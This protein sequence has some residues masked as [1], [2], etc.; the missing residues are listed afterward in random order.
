MKRKLILSGMILGATLLVACEN[1]EKQVQKVMENIK[2]A[3]YE[4]AYELYEEKIV[5][6]SEKVNDLEN[7]IKKYL[8]NSQQE[9]FEE[10]IDY[11]RLCDIIEEVKKYELEDLEELLTEVE[12]YGEKF[13]NSRTAYV[14]A[15]EYMADGDYENAMKYYG[16]V[17]ADDSYAEEAEKKKADVMETYKKEIL[18]KAEE[19][20]GEGNYD[21]ALETINSGLDI[22]SYDEDLFAKI[23]TYNAG[24]E[25]QKIGTVL[26]E[27]KSYYDNKDYKTAIQTLE[28]ANVLYHA[29]AIETTLSEYEAEYLKMVLTEAEQAFTTGGHEAA[30]SKLNEYAELLQ[31][32]T[33]Y[34]KKLTYYKELAPDM[35]CDMEMFYNG[36]AGNEFESGTTQDNF[37]NDFSDYLSFGYV[38]LKG[39][40]YVE[41]YLG[42]DYKT[43]T[44]RM[45]VLSEKAE[46]FGEVSIYADDILVY[47]SGKLMQKTQPFEFGIDLTNVEYLKIS[48]D[49][50][51]FEILLDCLQL[52]K[53]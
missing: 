24:K 25:Q 38:G 39:A 44:G 47:S 51:Y 2:N 20:A 33:G 7:E 45:G 53:Y 36:N 49:A 40:G 17:H 22:L 50:D 37:G 18:S 14:K 35:L 5:E 46:G 29:S 32:D 9:Y 42:G 1:A 19:Y 4:D 52:N 6:D 34:L 15:E 16:K 28:S 31:D 23:E 30:I 10:K 27:A 3:Q 11:E 8:E 21:E 48:Y 26:V 13:Y 43:L 12:K 41:Y